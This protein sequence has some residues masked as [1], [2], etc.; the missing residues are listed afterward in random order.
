MPKKRKAILSLLFCQIEN[1]N[2]NICPGFARKVPGFA[3]KYKKNFVA[4]SNLPRKKLK[5]LLERNLDIH[6]W[7][8]S[9]ERQF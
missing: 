1:H 2:T 5:K 3:R 6:L 9:G 4:V 7:F 8:I